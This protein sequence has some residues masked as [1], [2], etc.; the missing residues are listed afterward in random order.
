MLKDKKVSVIKVGAV[1]SLDGF[2]YIKS[3]YLLLGCVSIRQK[4]KRSIFNHVQVHRD[5]TTME[6]C[7]VVPKS[8]REILFVVTL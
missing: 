5:A 3:T 7:C 4:S 2:F 6:K 1:T 8:D